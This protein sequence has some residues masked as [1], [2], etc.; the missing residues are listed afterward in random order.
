[1]EEHDE[2]QERLRGLGMHPVDPALRS[3]HLTAMAQLR[4][5]RLLGS[6]LRV[7][8][9]FL[10]GLLLGGSGLAA[11][12][13]LP[14]PAQRVA[15]GVLDQVGLDVPNP[16]R[17]H[18]PECG[19]VRKNHGGYV[20]EDHS[21]AESDCGKP[22]HAGKVD[23]DPREPGKADDPDGSERPDKGPCQGPPPW[24]GKGGAAMSPEEKTVAQ[25]KR[26][27]QCGED[28]GTEQRAPSSTV[29]EPSTTTSTTEA[30]TT[31]VTV[32]P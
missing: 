1:M 20:R 23:D 27:A 10:A 19:E 21:L 25:A 16:E 30:S 3:A 24:A 5:R 18:G 29:T 6:K 15:H 32:A 2:I 7:A 17:Y 13:A 12:G 14:D 31:T 4:P 11:A 22:V 8:T 28:E 9:A 26:R